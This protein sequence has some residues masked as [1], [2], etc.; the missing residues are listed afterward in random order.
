MNTWN[1][2][3]R[4]GGQRN[5]GGLGWKAYTIHPKCA[6]RRQTAHTTATICARPLEG[7]KA[8]E[9]TLTTHQDES[10]ATPD[11]RDVSSVKTVSGK[12]AS[13]NDS[14][15]KYGPAGHHD[16]Y[17][18]LAGAA[19]YGPKDLYTNKG[20]SEEEAEDEEE[21]EEEEDIVDPKETL[22]QGESRS[23]RFYRAVIE[24]ASY[25]AH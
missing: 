18:G 20:N 2:P 11:K 7:Y 6:V 14:S 8:T 23:T 13:G 22:E 17:H 24:W 10:G 1:T 4:K 12:E 15:N 3:R 16:D 19:R 21:E 5:G 9:H 25:A